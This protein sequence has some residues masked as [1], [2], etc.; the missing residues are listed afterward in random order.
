MNINKINYCNNFNYQI[1]KQVSKAANETST[2]TTDVIKST[3][4][5]YYPNFKQ[6]PIAKL[7]EEYNWYINNDRVPALKSFLKIKESP[8]VMDNFLTEILK[9][10]DRS[11]EFFDSFLYQPRE[12]LRVLE[13][14]REKV[15]ANSKNTMC[16]M[17][18]SPYYQAY[19]N[20]LE[21]KYNNEKS[22][23]SLL[24][25][26]PDWSGKALLEKYRALNGNDNLVIGN[27]PKEIPTK[28]LKQLV[29]YLRGEMEIG[30][31]YKKK[32]NSL[33]LDNRKYDFAFFTEGR[34][35]K[36][37]FGIFTP[38]G[39]KYILKMGKPESR[40]L[41]NPFALGTLAKI[42]NYLTTH[43][44]RNSA[45]ICYYNHNDNYSIYKYIEHIPVQGE[46]KSLDVINNH[47][48]D[49]KK[50][51]LAYN[52]TVG[53]KNFFMLKPESTDGILNTEG[54]AEGVKNQEWISVDNDHVTYNN[55]LQP[56]VSKYCRTLPN[57][58]QMFF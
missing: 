27:V 45:P 4:A 34:S 17:Y 15:G 36:N 47:I 42:D 30:N 52:D 11:V 54:F 40:S 9:T 50:L 24:K 57:A 5:F 23:I 20:Y 22:L 2:C 38:E 33:T 7:Y 29:D 1:K 16:F 3:P 49:F 12:N 37:V 26:R 58:M 55:F 18:D 41:D 10:K 51:G 39:K 6:K 48:T 32:I 13:A 21:H 14:L 19:N 35:D 8:E 31:K 44:C 28:H 25:I 46:S 56:M 53:D 43:R